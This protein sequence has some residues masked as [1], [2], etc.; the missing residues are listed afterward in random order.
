VDDVGELDHGELNI[1][2]AKRYGKGGIDAA[3]GRH[4]EA[5]RKQAASDWKARLK[6]ARDA[7]AARVRLTAAD[8]KDAQMVKSSTGWHKV[9]RV[10]AK[11]VTVE[12][13]YPWTDRLAIDKVL[14]I[15]S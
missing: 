12:T 3:I 1:S 4:V 13:G 14:E 5:E 2:L 6:Q 11:T 8:L 10:N 15:R 9:V 7:E